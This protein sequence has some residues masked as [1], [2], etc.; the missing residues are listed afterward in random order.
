MDLGCIKRILPTNTYLCVTLLRNSHVA[1]QP[2]AIHLLNRSC[3]EAL[4][5]RSKPFETLA[6]PRGELLGVFETAG[7]HGA[8][9][10]LSKG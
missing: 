6:R 10:V 4:S 9:C 8:L 2:E 7:F 1:L 3:L 5:Q